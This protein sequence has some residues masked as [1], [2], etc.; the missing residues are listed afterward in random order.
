[1]A[2]VCAVFATPPVLVG[3]FGGALSRGNFAA[4]V[5]A[6][7]LLGFLAAIG[8]CWVWPL[9]RAVALFSPSRGALSE[10]ALLPGMGDVRQQLQQLLLA[11]IG[12]PAVGLVTLLI[13]AVGVVWRADLPDAIYWKVMIEF[14]LILII[15]L[16]MV[17][18]QIARPRAGGAWK[19]M[20]LFMMS[21]IWILSVL[22]WTVPLNVLPSFSALRWL[23][24]LTLAVALSGLVFMV[25]SAIHSVREISRRPHPFVEISS[26]A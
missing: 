6:A 9:S 16:P 10:L 2:L 23:V 13:I 7:E 1:V 25:G 26:K 14:L 24:W 21:Q 20:P 12:V 15:T 3:V 17:L 8:L 4:L 19:N 11:A 5:H 18:G 22:L